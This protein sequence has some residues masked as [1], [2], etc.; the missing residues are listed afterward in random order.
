[1][2]RAK[3][4][5]KELQRQANPN[6]VISLVGNKLDLES[7]R[8]VPT[9]E[10]KA[11]AEEEGLLFAEASAKTGT[12]VMDV[13]FEIGKCDFLFLTANSTDEQSH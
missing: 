12:N 10:A 11:Y 13:F 2:D 4:W 5:V 3:A 1:M 6:I 8:V 7:E 9:E